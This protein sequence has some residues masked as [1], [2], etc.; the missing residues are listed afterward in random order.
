[1][2]RQE[3]NNSTH[4]V[5]RTGTRKEKQYITNTLRMGPNV[6]SLFL[7]EEAGFD[8]IHKQGQYQISDCQTQR[9]E[10]IQAYIT[11]S[12]LF[13]LSCKCRQTDRWTHTDRH[14]HTYVCAHTHN[15]KSHKH[16]P[17]HTHTHTYEQ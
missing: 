12:M 9:R 7:Q 16:A 17:L 3:G 13:L 6:F 4:Y 15:T 8:H 10:M 2:M 11:E 14:T 5:K 1:M